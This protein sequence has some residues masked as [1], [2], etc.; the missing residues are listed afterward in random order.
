MRFIEPQGRPGRPFNAWISHWPLLGPITLASILHERG[1][2]VAIYNENV[3]GSLLENPAAYADIC[4]ADVVGISIMTPTA[5]RGY[6]LARAI[7][8]D[9][10][11]AVVV[12][13][14][15]HATFMPQ[16]A[17]SY[18]DVVVRGEG[19]SVIEAIAR[20][21]VAGGVIEA[22][23][24]NDLDE[25][26]ALRYDLVIDFDKLI[27]RR[28]R[29]EL[30]E[31][32]I[33]TSRGCPYGCTYCSVT[34][35]FGRKV[36]R[37]SV[38][39]VYR[40]VCHYVEQGFRRLFFYDDNFTSDRTWTRRLLERLRGLRIAFNAQ[41]RADFQWLDASRTKLDRPLLGAMRRAG[42]DVLYIG[43][44]T[45]DDSTAE[46]WNKGYRGRGSLRS[47][48][49]EDTSI[50]HDNGFWIHGM[51]VMGPQHT[52]DAADGIVDF[53]RQSSMETMQIS[54][55]TPLP[56][57]PVYEEMRPHLIF[58]DY[59]SDWDFYDGAHCVYGHSRLGLE[60]LQ[61]TVLAAH[62]RFY[63]WGGWSARRVRAFVRQRAPLVDKL[64]LLWS[65]ARTARTTLREWTR[66]M[67]SFLELAGARQQEYLAGV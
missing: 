54:I 18:G 31:L 53:A 13:G 57:T 56:G 43:Y 60:A 45:I 65:N 11:G 50:L 52:R 39:K 67:K 41:T 7:K 20:G 34:R 49:M 10:P 2:P 4:S 17:L 19:E 26:P 40:D 28:R 37:Q 61:R 27:G 24:L 29:R 32:P 62:R 16:E 21:E 23:A 64:G 14:G 12:F 25:I 44:E 38:E 47:R 1:V 15:V 30:Y 66:E 51:F 55:L 59:P 63:R 48:L 42:G 22:P 9:S 3:S 5:S 35:M 46:R 6:E 33:V 36:R 8:R 58:T